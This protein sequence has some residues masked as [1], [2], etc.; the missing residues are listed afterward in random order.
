MLAAQQR[1]EEQQYGDDY[2][3]QGYDN[4]PYYTDDEI[5]LLNEI[6][7][8]AETILPTLP[9]QN[10]LPTEALFVAAEEIFPKHGY[11]PDSPPSHLS[12]FIFKIG[13]HRTGET[14]S[15]K[16][17]AVLEG[18]G[19]ELELV[20]TSPAGSVSAQSNRSSI[21]PSSFDIGAHFS[22]GELS[23]PEERDLSTVGDTEHVHPTPPEEV[24]PGSQETQDDTPPPFHQH[25]RVPVEDI[26]ALEHRLHQF[27]VL[28][29][30]K[31]IRRCLHNWRFN[32]IITR[33]DN[34]IAELRASD[35]DDADIFE[36]VLGI[37]QEEAIFSQ[38]E[39]A[40]AQ[41][42]AEHEAYVAKMEKRAQRVYEILTVQKVLSH[43]HGQ[44]LEEIERTAVARRHLVRKRAFDGWRAQ[45]I[46]DEMKV[47]NF[48]LIHALQKWTQVALHLEVRQQVAAQRYERTLAQ[49]VINA[50]WEEV[51]GQLAHEFYFFKL[52]QETLRQ[53]NARARELEDEMEVAAA[54]DDRL[55][56]F[57]VID[58]WREE[59][60]EQQYVGYE[61]RMQLLARSC[62]RD[63]EYWHEQARLERTLRQF[64]VHQ[65]FTT[66]TSLLSTWH[67]AAS[68]LRQRR[69]T[70]NSFLLR[71]PLIHW[72]RETKLQEFRTRQDYR[73]QSS[74]LDHWILEEKLA[75]YKRHV[76]NQTLSSTLTRF[77]TRARQSRANHARDNQD[78]LAEY[79]YYTKLESVDKWLAAASET[80]K[81]RHNA[82][83][84][85]LYR[86]TVPVLDKWKRQS[87]VRVAHGATDRRTADINARRVTVGN[88][89]DV[90]PG[91]AERQKRER[92]LNTLR[93]FRRNYKIQL[94]EECLEHWWGGMRDMIG[95]ER[96]AA[97]V[98]VASRRD[99]VNEA[100]E[101]WVERAAEKREM[102]A[103]AADAEVEV[104]M[105][106]WQSRM[107]EMEDLRGAAIGIDAQETIQWCWS[108]LDFESLQR[109]AMGSSVAAVREKNDLRFCGRV[110]ERWYHL[111][112]PDP[113]GLDDTAD[114]SVY[115]PRFSILSRASLRV[116]DTPG[117]V[118]AA[119]RSTSALAPPGRPFNDNNHLEGDYDSDG[120]P[121]DLGFMS[122]PSRRL[123]RPSGGGG[124]TGSSSIRN[125][126]A[127][128]LGRVAALN[129]ATTTPSAIL[130]SPYERELR[131]A[132]GGGRTG[133]VVEFADIREE[134]AE[135]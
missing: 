7:T 6:V 129:A 58:I 20:P 63:L 5:E 34:G 9:E 90:W 40:A 37:W 17:R 126:N 53:W 112:V 80:W 94:A 104:L 71:S 111:A 100:L 43:W 130:P 114:P 85:Y 127:P 65:N 39:K 115:D 26:H 123:V 14:L 84:I 106:T 3:P 48:V 2:V 54:S 72:H 83:L 64:I 135:L 118:P 57:E 101:H 67:H 91:K 99:E 74:T 79:I 18:M 120:G 41:V 88:V 61:G 89:L 77:L 29:G 125:P 95:Q 31:I 13:G 103:I 78:A 119:A 70:A 25:T 68:R 73:L 49:M 107:E 1:L 66:Q 92:L 124:G 98:L 113:V 102:G 82:N 86:T 28:D 12:R 110:L 116:R 69:T 134:S 56:L 133:R 132:R 45:H 15:D 59:T 81:P 11:D 117:S 128:P 121:P 50:M 4:E 52:G 131:R 44:A 62:I 30:Q 96:Q 35:Y 109:R 8:L 108:R 97:G 60:E 42:A 93:E 22:G 33:R 21:P 32:A 55:I 36:E 51:K 105:S 23:E 38:E 76:Y 46:E 24:S 19:V 16:F 47:Q 87:R 122:T 10:R 27:R 75:W